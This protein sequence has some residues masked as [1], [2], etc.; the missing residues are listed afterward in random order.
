MR[1]EVTDHRSQI[2]QSHVFL[3]VCTYYVHTQSLQLELQA[4]NSRDILSLP[5][6]CL[7]IVLVYSWATL[8]WHLTLYHLLCYLRLSKF[9]NPKVYCEWEKKLLSVVVVG[10]GVFLCVPCFSICKK[11]LFPPYW[12]RGLLLNMVCSMYIIFL[13][14]PPFSLLF[15]FFSFISI[16]YLKKITQTNGR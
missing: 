4:S 7:C 2:T 9:K 6:A 14:L 5:H 8:P 11:D 15:H 10:V 13:H 16:I 3:V 1:E 12:N